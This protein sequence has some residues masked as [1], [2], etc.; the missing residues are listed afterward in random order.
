MVLGRLLRS[1]AKS[2]SV[3]PAKA[4]QGLQTPTVVCEENM[5]GCDTLTQVTPAAVQEERRV[6]KD[7]W[8]RNAKYQQCHQLQ[9]ANQPAMQQ[10]LQW[11]GAT[12]RLPCVLYCH[13]ASDFAVGK[14]FHWLVA[15]SQDHDRATLH[16]AVVAC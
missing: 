14:A 8:V 6:I 3:H 13:A 9:D 12:M 4:N 10:Q 16:G 2:A 11:E 7:D 1:P 5:A 15:E